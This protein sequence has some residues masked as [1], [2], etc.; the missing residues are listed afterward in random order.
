MTDWQEVK[1]N[2][3]RLTLVIGAGASYDCFYSDSG[4]ANEGYRPPL[5]NQIFR[6]N[7]QFNAILHKYPKAEALSDSIRTEINIKKTSLEKLLLTIFNRQGLS[8]KKQYWQI[9]L[10]LQELFG[11]ITQHFVSGA[12]KYETLI[13]KIKNSDLD[14]VLILTVNYDLFLERAF[15]KA[16]NYEFRKPESY[17]DI[18]VDDKR[19]H[20]IKLHGS[21]NWGRKIMNIPAEKQI[22]DDYLGIL[23]A[24]DEEMLLD[25]KEN[26][27]ILASHQKRKDDNFLY[28]PAISVPIE[29]KTEF[30]IA[31]KYINVA[32]G[33]IEKCS[34]LL[35]LGFSG[36]DTHVL[37]KLF[38]KTPNINLVKFVNGKHESGV[39]TLEKLSKY[40]NSFAEIF[41]DQKIDGNFSCS[42]TG[43]FTK[44]DN[45]GDL[46]SF[47]EAVI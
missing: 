39:K 44:F 30:A 6:N 4:S 14:E 5:V 24:Y 29:G 21:S 37:E 42:Y 38:K 20:I 27:T 41:T 31:D 43:G 7:D 46:D 13:D 28:F 11:E 12:T 33:F 26:I 22:N 35:V 9:P 8:S 32:K 19:F 1:D 17:L 10:Y 34:N 2:T 25:N 47:L 18:Q 15:Q 3:K 36:N 40:S 23:N 45:D 16:Y